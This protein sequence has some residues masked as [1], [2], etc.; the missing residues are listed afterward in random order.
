[1]L[2]GKPIH[3]IAK[4]PLFPGIHSMANLQVIINKRVFDKLSDS[5]KVIL[6]AM[7]YKIWTAKRRE[8][9]L[10]GLDQVAKDKAGG[11]L[12]IIDWPLEERM[13]FRKIAVDAWNA[14]AAKSPLAKE[15]LESNLAYMRKIGILD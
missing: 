7:T 15:A 1:M 8:A 14:A 5:E 6:E 9:N 10:Q 2:H 11:D 12:T 3:K 13:K 4:Y